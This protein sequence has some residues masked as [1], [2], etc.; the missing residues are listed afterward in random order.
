MR[1][2]SHYSQQTPNEKLKER[3]RVLSTLLH[4]S[5]PKLYR[6]IVS[7]MKSM[8]RAMD[9]NAIWAPADS[10]EYQLFWQAAVNGD[11]AQLATAL[12]PNID[13]N[14]LFGDGFEGHSVLHET[15]VRGHVDVLRYLLSHGAALD[16]LDKNQFGCSTPLYYAAKCAQVGATR[17]LL[18]A[19]ADITVKGPNDNTILSAVLPDSVQVT[20]SQI[21]TI[22]ILLDRGFDVNARASINGPTVVSPLAKLSGCDLSNA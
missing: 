11:K 19:R 13:V 16:I 6:L 12:K 14:A 4:P 22:A 8:C 18:D 15:S 1:I 7:R 2:F 5:S 21:D 20:Q 3:C 10:E 17:V 9:E